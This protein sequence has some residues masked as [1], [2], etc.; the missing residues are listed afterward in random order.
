MV[1]NKDTPKQRYHIIII[2]EVFFDGFLGR[3]F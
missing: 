2:F 1:N 3:G